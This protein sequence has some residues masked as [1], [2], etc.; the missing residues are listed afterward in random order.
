MTIIEQRFMEVL[1]A[2]LPRVVGEL[3]T[4]NRLKALEIKMHLE[5]SRNGAGLSGVMLHGF[6]SRLDEIMRE[7]LK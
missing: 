4:A 7:K 1:C 3:A 2:N 6:E 5:Q